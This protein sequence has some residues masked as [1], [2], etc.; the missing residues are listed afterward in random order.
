MIGDSTTID[1]GDEG[2]CWILGSLSAI[3]IANCLGAKRT[4]RQKKGDEGEREEVIH[5]MSPCR[6]EIRFE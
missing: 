3:G 4:S 5:N 2:A 6:F 1:I